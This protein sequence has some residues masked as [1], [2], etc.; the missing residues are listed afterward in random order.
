MNQPIE[1]IFYESQK[2]SGY[3]LQNFGNVFLSKHK[4]TPGKRLFDSTIN[5]FMICAEKFLTATDGDDVRT[6]AKVLMECFLYQ[7]LPD[8][9]TRIGGDNVY[10]FEVLSIDGI[11]LNG[12]L[13]VFRMGSPFD[14]LTHKFYCKAKWDDGYNTW[15]I[16]YQNDQFFTVTVGPLMSYSLISNY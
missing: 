5:D 15:I 8:G 11:D 13:R 16:K 7:S 10:G 3:D 12:S 14:E 6:P 1:S 4:L 2:F 9:Y